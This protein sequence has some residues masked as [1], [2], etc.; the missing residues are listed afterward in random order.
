LNWR[1]TAY[2]AVKFVTVAAGVNLE[3]LDWGGSG[4]V[5]VSL[6][7]SGDNAHVYDYFAF[8]FTVSSTLLE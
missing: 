7:G 5:M 6:T 1:P 8:Q 4:K 2:E 3:V